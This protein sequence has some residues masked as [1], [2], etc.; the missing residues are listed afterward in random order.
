ME[1]KKCFCH[2]EL[3]QY[4]FYVLYIVEA[5]NFTKITIICDIK[6]VF[7]FQTVSRINLTN[8]VQF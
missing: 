3:L 5:L 4:I 8:S 6:T 2:G 7:M 1:L